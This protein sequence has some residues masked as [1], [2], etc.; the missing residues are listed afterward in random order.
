MEEKHGPSCATSKKEKKAKEYCGRWETLAI[1][2]EMA[3]E[4][5]VSD[6]R[7]GRTKKEV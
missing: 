3:E 1:M 2:R 4:R 7:V 5:I 6:I